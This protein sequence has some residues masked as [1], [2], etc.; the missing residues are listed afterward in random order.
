MYPLIHPLELTQLVC[1]KPIYSSVHS[2]N[3]KHISP[4]LK[5]QFFESSLFTNRNYILF[6]RQ[7]SPETETEMLCICVSRINSAKKL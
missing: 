7:I 2:K 1:Q 6:K 3:G 4:T 5:N